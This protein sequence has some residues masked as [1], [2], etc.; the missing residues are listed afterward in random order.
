M[1][2]FNLTDVS[3][4]VLTQYGIATSSIAVGRHL[5]DPGEMVD[6]PEDPLTLMHLEHFIKIGALAVD[7]I[8]PAYILAKDRMPKEPGPGLVRTKPKE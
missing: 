7:S 4:K 8:P 1:R 6:V 5:V 2:I 3:T